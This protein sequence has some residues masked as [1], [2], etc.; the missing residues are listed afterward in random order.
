LRSLRRAQ[1]IAAARALVAA[2]GLDALTIGALEQRLGF[3]RGVITYHFRDKD[4]I[5]AALL[6]SAVA[7]IDAASKAA[8][9]AGPTAE[10]KVRAV[11]RANLRGFLEH[12]EAGLILLSFWGRLMADPKARRTNASLFAKYRGLTRS[13]IEAGVKEGAFTKVDADAISALIVGIVIGLAAQAYFEAGAVDERAALEE[14]ARCV[15]A[16]LRR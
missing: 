1:I 15:L 11:L 5:V 3:S 14:A 7:E 16:R 2:E 10:D 9:A 8:V 6:E 13:V 12:R 4:E